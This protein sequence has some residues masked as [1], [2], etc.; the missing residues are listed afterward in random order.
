MPTLLDPY[1]YFFNSNR[2]QIQKN[3]SVGSGAIIDKAK[4]LIVTNYHVIEDASSIEIILADSKKKLT[5]T[6]IGSD[7][8]TDIALLRA[9]IPS[10]ARALEL[11]NSDALRVGDV[12]LAIGNPFGYGHTVTSG[13]ISAKGRVLGTGPYDHFLQT[14]ASIHPGNSGGPLV[15]LRGRVVGI[16]S[17]VEKNAPGIGFAIPANIVKKITADLIAHGKVIRPWLGVIVK[18]ILSRE[19]LNFGPV[20][21]EGVYG[22]IVSNIVV[23]GPAQTSGFKVGDLIMGIDKAKISDTADLQRTLHNKKIGENVSV[24][25]YRA[26]SG[27]L[28]LKVKLV[29]TPDARDLPQEKDLF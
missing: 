8:K 17:A 7:P 3:Y 4:G 14:D 26:Q 28:T 15:D 27:N 29:V 5:A 20:A 13:I 1:E 9:K 10:D 18:N 21:T 19:E 22:V 11:G 2:P 25:I 6:V 24:K 12:V 23:S 16:N